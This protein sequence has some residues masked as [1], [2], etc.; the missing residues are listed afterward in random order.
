MDDFIARRDFVALVWSGPNAKRMV[1]ITGVCQS[2][3]LS[4]YL[5]GYAFLHRS[6][7][8]DVTFGNGKDAQ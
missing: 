2:V 6:M 1:V 3:S 7:D 8:L 4:V 5:P